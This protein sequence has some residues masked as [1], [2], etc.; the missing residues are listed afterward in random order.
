V[1]Y[2]NLYNKLVALPINWENEGIIYGWKKKGI[3]APKSYVPTGY[4]KLDQLVAKWSPVIKYTMPD[5]EGARPATNV[6]EKTIELPPMEG[7]IRP[8]SYPYMLLHELGHWVGAVKGRN[9][10]PHNYFADTISILSGHYS[11]STTV[12]E[13]LAAERFAQLV[14]EQVAP[15]VT[16]P[17][18]NYLA[19]W[20]FNAHQGGLQ[21]KEVQEVF[22][23]AMDEAE[24]SAQYFLGRL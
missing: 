5:R 22:D 15:G 11:V 2:S 16:A 13:E 1:K 17:A 10:S 12:V 18:D 24:A 23:E 7:F 19:A 20:V 4:A 3:I 21:E 8:E 6:R 9:W 14:A